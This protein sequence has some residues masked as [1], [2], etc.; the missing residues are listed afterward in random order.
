MT[1]F[2]YMPERTYPLLVVA[3]VTLTH[4]PALDSGFHYDDR[5][6][7]L[8]NPHIR[9]LGQIPRAFSPIPPLFPQIRPMRCTGRWC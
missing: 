7:L 8:D 9:D 6:S 1:G 5:H 2:L 3:L 4:A